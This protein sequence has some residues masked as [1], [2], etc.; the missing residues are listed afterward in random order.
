MVIAIIGTSLFNVSDHHEALRCSE[1]TVRVWKN[2]SNVVSS[3][4][5]KTDV[6]RVPP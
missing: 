6:T 1:M 3:C 2:E 4:R 5:L